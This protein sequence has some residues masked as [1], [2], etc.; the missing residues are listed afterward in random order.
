MFSTYPKPE[1]REE[2]ITAL[3]IMDP[4][5]DTL[6]AEERE[7]MIRFTLMSRQEQ[8]AV[9]AE[10][11][12]DLGKSK[13][14]LAEFEHNASILKRNVQKTVL[15]R[16]IAELELQ[17]AQSE[18]KI[19]EFEAL[20][21]AEK[22]ELRRLQGAIEVKKDE[23]LGADD[24][25]DVDIDNDND[26]DDDLQERIAALGLAAAVQ[27]AVDANND[28]GNAYAVFVGI[29][30]NNGTLPAG[31]D[32]SHNNNNSSPKNSTFGGSIGGNLFQ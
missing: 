14:Q 20:I 27:E 28:G 10:S 29:N 11:A 19:K 32:Q 12:A 6:S 18:L 31:S 2:A 17:K 16:E 9:M 25:D 30:I 5:F 8:L 15:D 3:K 1:T 26:L 4:N 24:D 13:M 23:Q 21:V 22:L 7:E